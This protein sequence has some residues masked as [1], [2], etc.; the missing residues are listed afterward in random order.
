MS[1]NFNR[2]GANTFSIRPASQTIQS[3]NRGKQKKRG[4][5][6]T[7]DQAI[8]FKEA[9]KYSGANVS[10]EAYCESNATLKFKNEKTNPN[11]IIRG[12]DENYIATSAYEIEKGRNF[13]NSE[14]RKVIVGYD[15][16]KSLFNEKPE[17]AIN[18]EIR[19]NSDK[20]TIVGTLKKRG[21]S[22][23]GNEDRRVFIPLITAK[24]KYGYARK[25]YNVSISVLKP[26]LTDDAINNTIG[27]FRNIRG[28]KA[29]EENDFAIR[30]SDSILETLKEMTTTLR[31][32]T[33]IIAMLTLLGASI[34]LMNIMLVTVT[35]RTKEIGVRKALGATRKNILTQFMIEA[36][37]ICLMGGILGI[38]LGIIIGMLVTVLVK[39][40]FFIPWA[41]MMLGLIVC[42]V[43][44]IIS[45]LY[46]ALKASQL[47]PIESLR[48]E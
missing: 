6:I 40:Q 14:T 43:V 36:V 35:E 32:S 18:K 9:Y 42:I 46:P 22:S 30:K 25:N 1:D 23:G 16:V 39:G 3:K 13:T 8:S 48:Y 15:I 47:D 17:K 29:G 28:L 34:G 45:G 4:E 11:V 24:Q 19:I 5:P 38:I 33:I 26:D 7:Y 41:W 21:S 44:G 12:I 2:L 20:F 10:V 31:W 37:V 27:I